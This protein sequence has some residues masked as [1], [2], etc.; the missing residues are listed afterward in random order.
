MAGKAKLNKLR[1]F[2]YLYRVFYFRKYPPKL[3][4]DI[5]YL[6]VEY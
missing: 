4:K 2:C 3:Q 6:F 1:F 5:I